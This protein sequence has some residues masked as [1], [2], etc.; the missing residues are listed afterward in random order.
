[1]GISCSKKKKKRRSLPSISCSLS[2]KSEL[3]VNSTE[4]SRDNYSRS[5][6][7]GTPSSRFRNK[8]KSGG[9][10]EDRLEHPPAYHELFPESGD[11]EV[12][13]SPH[14][15][16]SSRGTD[17][18]CETSPR[19]SKFCSHKNVRNSTHSGISRSLSRSSS[20]SSFSSSSSLSSSSSSSISSSSSSSSS[21]SCNSVLSSLSTDNQRH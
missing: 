1:M 13:R 21:S 4:R 15:A 16:Q 7:S 6:D 9:V 14:D 19:H 17:L 5:R 2:S 10:V 18:N 20:S 11:L 12:R 8:E 3:S